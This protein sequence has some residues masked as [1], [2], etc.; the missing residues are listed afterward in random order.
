[1]DLDSL[2]K[3]Q[4]NEAVRKRLAKWMAQFSFRN[5]KLED[6]YDRFNDEEMKTLRIDVVNHSYAFLSILFCTGN[7][8]KLIE[9][10]NEK[11]EVPE[12]NDPE[13]S[14]ELIET[15]RRVLKLLELHQTAA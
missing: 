12:W 10:L 13:I 8:N 2:N 11:D 9:L 14:D 4:H 7:S 6:F 15:A 3:I 5:T 1:M